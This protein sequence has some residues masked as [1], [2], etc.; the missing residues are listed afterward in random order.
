MPQ[1]DEIRERASAAWFEFRA[2]RPRDL[3]RQELRGITL[4]EILAHYRLQHH[5]ESFANRFTDVNGLMRAYNHS[6]H[7]QESRLIFYD[8]IKE[9][10]GLKSWQAN[11]LLTAL[12]GIRANEAEERRR[13]MKRRR[14]S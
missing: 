5:L 8:T 7:N 4:P 11:M 13:Q 6:R 9:T 1:R 2:K 3:T 12:K 10:G 14:T